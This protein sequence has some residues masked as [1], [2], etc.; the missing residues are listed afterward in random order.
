MPVR[1]LKLSIITVSFGI[2]F[3]QINGARD[4]YAY[5]DMVPCRFDTNLVACIHAN[6]HKSKS[7]PFLHE[8]VLSQ[9]IPG[10]FRTSIHNQ[11]MM[12]PKHLLTSV[13]S[14]RGLHRHNCNPIIAKLE[15]S[16]STHR[17]TYF[18]SPG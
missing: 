6:Q 13:N 4:L 16:T 14:L 1:K 17:Q 10:K 18:N 12:H 15:Q 11:V 5:H 7:S 9:N 3:L 8:T 2:I